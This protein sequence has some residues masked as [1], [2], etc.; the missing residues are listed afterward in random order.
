MI[1]VLGRDIRPKT[2]IRIMMRGYDK[3]DELCTYNWQSANIIN[4]TYKRG[5]DPTGNELPYMELRWEELYNGS[6]NEKSQPTI[7]AN[8]ATQL[9]VTLA[10]SQE[11]AF[12]PTWK[13]LY[14]N[15]TWN[16]I[17][18]AGYKWAFLPNVESFVMPKLYLS[19]PPRIEKN[20][21]IWVA[22]DIM[23]FL[24]NKISLAL[25]SISFKQLMLYNLTESRAM[26][27][28]NPLMRNTI[29][30]SIENIKSLTNFDVFG[31][32]ILVDDDVRNNLKNCASLLNCFFDFDE[33]GALVCRNIESKDVDYNFPEN[34]MYAWPNVTH[35]NDCYQYE[36]IQNQTVASS[37]SFIVEMSQTIIINDLPI[38]RFDFPERG[39]DA[40]KKSFNI[41]Y[42][43]D[44]SAD[45]REIKKLTTNS[46]SHIIID[47]NIVS[48]DVITENNPLC[49]WADNDELALARAEFLKTFAK[50]DNVVLDAETLILPMLEP[51]DRVTIKTNLVDAENQTIT[52]DCFVINFEIDYNGAVR[53]KFKLQ[54]YKEWN[55]V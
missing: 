45:S 32:N 44:T 17:Y 54:E 38:Y 51:C 15:N 42:V 43:L 31:K 3:N 29:Q 24:T 33:N 41:N 1:E 25:E 8:V 39:I 47:N 53:E 5:V 2:N 11:K 35:L 21:I 4:L 49:Y 46:Y 40:E 55:G 22:K 23:W 48:G 18:S 6:I 30:K 14:Q 20:K 10:F 16:Q 26:L 52:K 28:S 50:S 36:Y 9:E 7:Y 37:E 27:W 19:E 13:S 12:F 34:I